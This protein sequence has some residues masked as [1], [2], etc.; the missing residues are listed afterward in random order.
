MSKVEKLSLALT[1][2][3]ATWVREAVDSGAYA[4]SSEVVRD[5]L[6]GLRDRQ[7]GRAIGTEELRRL[8]DEGL[9]SGFSEHHR[10][11]AEIGAEGRRRLAKKR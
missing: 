2:E 3:L 4:S 7:S 8:I 11:A 5:A 9:A 6:R 1:T 10:S